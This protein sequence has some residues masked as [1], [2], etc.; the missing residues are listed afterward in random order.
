MLFVYLFSGECGCCGRVLE[1]NTIPSEDHDRILEEVGSYI[2]T[3]EEAY[4][5][6][7]IGYLKTLVQDH[8]FGAVIDGLNVG[9]YRGEFHADRVCD[10][11]QC[12]ECD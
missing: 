3:L 11:P 4:Y 9:T 12:W 5:S 6:S 2:T 10:Q 1:S 7:C 8:K